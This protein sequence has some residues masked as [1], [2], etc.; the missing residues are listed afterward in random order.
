MGFERRLPR[1]IFVEDVDVAADESQILHAEDIL[2]DIVIENDGDDQYAKLLEYIS[3]SQFKSLVTNRN[4]KQLITR[5]LNGNPTKIRVIARPLK[6]K[7]CERRSID[8]TKSL[9]LIGREQS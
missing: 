9:H 5:F 1:E 7:H 8:I 6:T 2:Q 3:S 4:Y